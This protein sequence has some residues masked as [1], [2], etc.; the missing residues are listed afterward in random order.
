[1]RLEPCGGGP[2]SAGSRG[3]NPGRMSRRLT[4]LAVMAIVVLLVGCGGSP[5]SS[6]TTG[7]VST[8]PTSSTTALSSTIQTAPSSATTSSTSTRPPPAP[9]RRPHS[10]SSGTPT[11]A[12]PT[13]ADTNVRVPATFT[14]RPGGALDPPSV[15]APGFFAIALTVISGD[16]RAHSVRVHAPKPYSLAVPAHGRASVLIP[17]L[18]TG[19]YVI[20]VDGATRGALS[21]GAQPGP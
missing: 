13:G 19:Q 1:M 7:T 20:E 6:S 12:R 9:T 21:I 8:A 16:G 14:I 5:S 3:S 17:G 15:S 4:V 18:R 11:R 2:A 10:S